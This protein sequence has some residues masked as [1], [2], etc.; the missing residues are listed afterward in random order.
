KVFGFDIRSGEVKQFAFD[1]PV[2]LL[3]ETDDSGTLLVAMQGGI[4]FLDLDS[5]ALKHILSL[6]TDKPNNRT[7]DGGCDTKGR[8]WVGTMDKQFETGAGHLYLVDKG[9]F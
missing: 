4:A 5:G 1:R 6:E 8:L 2:T 9:E 3:V 7:N